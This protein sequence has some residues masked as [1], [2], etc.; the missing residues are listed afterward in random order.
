M[1]GYAVGFLKSYLFFENFMDIYNEFWSYPSLIPY[2]KLCLGPFS[3]MSLN[4]IH[5]PFFCF[6]WFWLG[7]LIGF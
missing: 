2:I 4:Q 6:Y 3:S 7:M 1:E 5:D